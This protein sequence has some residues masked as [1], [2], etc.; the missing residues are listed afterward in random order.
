MRILPR[1]LWQTTKELEATVLAEIRDNHVGLQ[2]AIQMPLLGKIVGVDERRARAAVEAL[3]NRRYP[4][5]TSIGRPAGAFWPANPK[6]FW[7]FIHGNYRPRRLSM[8]TTEGAM[9]EGYARWQ[10]GESI[11]VQLQPELIPQAGRQD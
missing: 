9:I 5:C 6:E 8:E 1:Q 7:E 11:E 2:N 4:I 3:R 10:R